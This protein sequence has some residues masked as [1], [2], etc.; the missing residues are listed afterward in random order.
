M[1]KK[2]QALM[3]CLIMIGWI[4]NAQALLLQDDFEDGELGDRM[5]EVGLE[6]PTIVQSF[7]DPA[8]QVYNPASGEYFAVLPI[9]AA[10]IWTD[11]EWSKGDRLTFKYLLTEAAQG[12]LLL[13]PNW[14]YEG[15]FA[16]GMSGQ[17]GTWH[18]FSYEFTGSENG[19]LAIQNL[20]GGSYG[21]LLLDAVSYTKV[22][23]PNMHILGLI[24]LIA[25]L[26]Q[27]RS[28]SQLS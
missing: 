19:A 18:S 1:Q 7:T 20:L 16:D 15:N 21:H 12:A 22:T 5:Y 3:A 23:E 10:L 14:P 6:A 26:W 28:S 13:F 25:L 17:T 2:I 9:G 27:K 8:G 11:L 24:G 4:S